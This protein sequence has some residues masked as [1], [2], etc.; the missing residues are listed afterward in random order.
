MPALG[1]E[2]R[3]SLLPPEV[4][5]AKHLRAARGRLIAA[6]FLVF[7]IVVA[8]TVGA[9]FLRVA[10]EASLNGA[11]SAGE[12]L[13]VEQQKYV[14]LQKIESGIALIQAGQQVGASTEIDWQKYLEKL[15]ATLPA[16]VVIK[17]VSIESASPL[18]D[19][20]QSTVPLEGSRVATLTFTATSPTLP[21]IPDWLDGLSE[22]VGFADAVPGTVTLQDDGA[23]SVNITMHI[24]SE[25]FALRYAEGSK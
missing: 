1:G 7:V 12:S 16:G 19:Y 18:V 5:D 22:L 4:N 6:V 15:Q 2:P 25:A 11:R 10:A 20:T 23:Y 21:T 9:F 3:V 24:N 13:T 14:K 8:G 17:T